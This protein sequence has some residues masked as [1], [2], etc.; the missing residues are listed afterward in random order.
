MEV[1]GE[2]S[3][4]DAVLDTDGSF[5]DL[6]SYRGTAG[7]QLRIRMDSED[8]DTYLAI[9]RMEGGCGDFEEIATMDD[10]GD[11]TNT[12]L[13]ITLPE[14][15]EYVIRANSFSA[16]Q[17]GAYTIVVESSRDR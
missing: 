1:S 9:G 13:E 3:D 12:L 4:D 17:T 10:G 2:L 16:D 15:G 14:D 7:E 8:F 5:Y 11:G 6:W